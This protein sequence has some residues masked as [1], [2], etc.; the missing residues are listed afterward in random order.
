VATVETVVEGFGV[1]EGPVWREGSGDLTVTEVTGGRVLRVDV[2]RGEATT[3]AVT[4]GGPNGAYPCT[5]GGLLVT[6]NGG[7]DWEL[8]GYG[9]R[10]ASSPTTP[11]IQRTTA[12]GAV[13]LLTVDDGPFRAP[14]DLCVAPDGALW[15]TDPPQ[16]PP[17]PEPV[18][19]IW[20]WAAG[21]R[22]EVVADGLTYCNGIGIAADGGVVIVEQQGLMCLGADGTERS[23]LVE[24]LPATGDGFA[25]DVDG[26]LYLA[27]GPQVTVVAPDGGIVEVLPA[28]DVHVSNCCFGG[29]DLRSLYATDMR[30]RVLVFHDMPVS[31]RPLTPFP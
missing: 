26:N 3:F 16:F 27:G 9:D 22:P 18:G 1:L 17:P 5:D 13:T 10:A 8:L 23:W 11:G 2:T 29:A 24:R 20:R 4:D 19:R 28:S 31:G 6:Q 15:F 7:L 12:D 21:E 14:N 25:F 30:G